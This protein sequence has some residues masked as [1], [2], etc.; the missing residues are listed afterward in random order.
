MRNH[1]NTYEENKKGE[2]VGDIIKFD[3]PPF[4][5]KVKLKN[6]QSI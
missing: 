3:K 6:L 4:Q 1:M 5:V 2:R